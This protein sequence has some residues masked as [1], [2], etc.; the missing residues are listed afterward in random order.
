M[1][2]DRCRQWTV[3]FQLHESVKET[4]LGR[5]FNGPGAVCAPSDRLILNLKARK[6]P[7]NFMLGV[8]NRIRIY[9]S[10][11]WGVLTPLLKFSVN[12]F[13]WI[14]WWDFFFDVFI[15][16][17]RIPIYLSF[18]FQIM[19]NDRRCDYIIGKRYYVQKQIN[20]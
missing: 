19:F 4:L 3:I 14:F 15:S 13:Y 2:L 17:A 1:L 5:C 6:W 7:N 10:L 20:V 11:L 16:L 12:I 18:I 8:T 9:V